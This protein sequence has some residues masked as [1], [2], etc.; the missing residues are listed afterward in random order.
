MILV[1]I[2]KDKHS[3]RTSPTTFAALPASTDLGTIYSSSSIWEYWYHLLYQMAPSPTQPKGQLVMI[4]PEMSSRNL[5]IA[6]LIQLIPQNLDKAPR[7]ALTSQST[8]TLGGPCVWDEYKRWFPRN[9]KKGF[10]V[11]GFVHIPC[12]RACWDAVITV[13][14]FAST[15][16][17]ILSIPTTNPVFVKQS[18]TEWIRKSKLLQM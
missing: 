10:Y 6:P 16:Q 12:T 8:Y 9:I 18:E 7:W 14:I 2:E 15:L 4:L 5:L 3:V 13:Y 17:I 11:H 1:P